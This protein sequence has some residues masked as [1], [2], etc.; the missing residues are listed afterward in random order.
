MYRWWLR[1]SWAGGNGRVVC[2][3]MLNPSTADAEV[4]DPTIRRCM[5]FA[6]RWGFSHLSVRNLFPYRATSPRELLTA[7][8]PTGGARG[9]HELLPAVPPHMVIC[10]WG[11]W[12]P[13]ERDQDAL[14]I[15]QRDGAVLHCLGLTKH[16]K[17]RHP[18]YI[19][20]DTQ[21]QLLEA[22]AQG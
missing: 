20:A 15:L 17:P 12:I 6:Q 11:A 1:R 7:T 18:L 4:D 21:P 2:F 19:K 9:D 3:I 8:E 14:R 10:A 13:Y 5:S 16:G 22:V